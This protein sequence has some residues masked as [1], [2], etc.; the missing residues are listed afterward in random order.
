MNIEYIEALF[1]EFFVKH[2]PLSTM[3]ISDW[4]KQWYSTYIGCRDITKKSAA[5][6]RQKLKNY[7]IPA[8]GDMA[9][10]DVTELHLQSIVN[11][12]NSSKSNAQKVKIV[13]Q[14]MFRRAKSC[15]LI[16]VDPSENLVLP[17]APCGTHRSITDE[18]RAEILLL[19]EHHPAG[20]Y[21]LTLL[22]TG[23]RPGEAIALQWGDIDFENRTLNVRRAVE[24]GTEHDLKEPKTAAGIR[25]IP[26]SNY[27]HGRL[28]CKKGKPNEFVFTQPLTGNAHS[29]SSANALWNNFKRALD[30][31]MGAKLYR[32]KI[33]VHAVADDLVPYC[34]RHTYCTDLQRAG[35]PINVAKYLMGHSDISVTSNIYTSTTPDVLGQAK[36]S[37]D[38]FYDGL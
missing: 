29:S 20:L 5:M 17:K 35:V 38:R 27:L 3:S 21:V 2:C 36:E 24:S 14:S 19:A 26:I 25:V 16:L 13:I 6:Y 30:I 9:I 4:A 11:N 8:I 33:V 32:N 28:L 31:Q 1:E 12:A 15:G 10:G 37:M 22:L 34:L 23:I 18:E 7:I